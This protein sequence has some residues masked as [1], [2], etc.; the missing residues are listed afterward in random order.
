MA[1]ILGQIYLFLKLSGRKNDELIMSNLLTISIIDMI[2]LLNLQKMWS[3]W[4]LKIPL[5][6]YE[7]VKN[8]D[9]I[10]RDKHTTYW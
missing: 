1:H 8:I 2:Y 4:F 7:S 6:L 3:S 5:R 9:L 10:V